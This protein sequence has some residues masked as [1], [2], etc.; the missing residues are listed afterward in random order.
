LLAGN[1]CSLKF[2]DAIT[3]LFPVQL[4]ILEAWP[5]NSSHEFG[6]IGCLGFHQQMEMVGPE[7]I[8]V[9]FY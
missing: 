2:G 6:K 9:K 5:Q 1:F 3:R 7:D 8:G 4:G